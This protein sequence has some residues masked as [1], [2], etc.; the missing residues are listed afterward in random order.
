[1]IGRKRGDFLQTIILASLRRSI[2]GLA[3]LLQPQHRPVLSGCRSIIQWRMNAS[4]NV[5]TQVQSPAGR[6]MLG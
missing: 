2:S 3:M 1:M 5:P 4:N 6:L